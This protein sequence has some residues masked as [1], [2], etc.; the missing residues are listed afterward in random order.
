MFYLPRLQSFPQLIILAAFSLSAVFSHAQDPNAACATCHKDIYE[1]YKTTP[2][3]NASGPAV[4][5]LIPGDFTHQASGVHYRVYE[6]ADKQGQSQVYLS[7]ARDKAAPNHELIGRE[8][9]EYFIGS[10][11]RG[12]TYLFNKDGYWFEAPINWYGKKQL[13]DMAPN[14]LNAVTMPMTLE[15]DP[16]CLRCHTSNAAHSLPDARNHYAAAPFTESGITCT[17]CHGDATAHITS[18][19]KMPMLDID[20]LKPVRR[21]SVCLSCHLEGQTAVVHAG[22][23]LVDFKPGDNLFDYA[24][25][26]VRSSVVGSG[27]RATSQWEALVR[28]EC[29]RKSGD[30]LTC[31]TC[32]D[33][34]STPA[35]S[36]SNE[37]KITFFR[38]KCLQC[39]ATLATSHHPDNP[40]CAGCHMA[41]S[42]STDIAH[43]QVT[44]HYIVKH[45]ATGPVTQKVGVE[46]TAVGG[47]TPSDRDLGIAYAH[48][49]RPGDT[50]SPRRAAT[51]LKKAEDES[52]G[53]P[54]DR[55]LHD[56]LGFLYQANGDS[57]NAAAEYK[58]ALAAD[59][60]DSLAAGNL[61][62]IDA[63]QHHYPA[64]IKLWSDVFTH[65]PSE[66]KA[67][68]N[69]AIV[70]CQTGMRT[71][72]L[73]TLSR[74]LIYDPDNATAH[75]FQAK[76]LS[77][78]ASCTGK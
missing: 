14:Y 65:H 53:A 43:E 56:Q 44:D 63:Q 32:H 18:A 8:Q 41:R 17:A 5:G 28:S 15:V 67:A 76:I 66:T 36:P 39:H 11:N 1:R 71:E 64:A 72:T 47:F 51:L 25:F 60:Y 29:K 21:D 38:Q 62:Y 26:F 52:N 61:A 3:A 13:W 34:H 48:L 12:R 50:E 6:E 42:T 16:G 10:G 20:A 73:T 24:L 70:K 4:A 27:G 77:S 23:E 58:L 75:A 2:M 33:P 7:Y 74:L 22:K 45:P 46:L 30:K 57:T 40:D 55:E 69:L 59:A 37:E 35:P 19:G 31:T 9:L 78:T 49:S 68:M 54:G